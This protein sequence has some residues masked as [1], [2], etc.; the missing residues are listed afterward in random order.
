MH[1][2]YLW[3]DIF[4][5]VILSPCRHLFN[6]PLSESGSRGNNTCRR[7]RFFASAVGGAARFESSNCSEPYFKILDQMR[8]IYVVTG[9]WISP[10]TPQHT[11]SS[12]S[13]SPSF[14]SDPSS[15][16]TNEIIQLIQRACWTFVEFTNTSEPLET[17]VLQTAASGM[18]AIFVMLGDSEAEISGEGWCPISKCFNIF[19]YWNVW[20]Y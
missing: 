17:Y 8:R 3:L 11:I 20:I 16:P 7:L 18:C 1:E 15:T 9:N 13:K 4:V 5:A 19:F 6:R 12:L 10:A 14:A 2:K